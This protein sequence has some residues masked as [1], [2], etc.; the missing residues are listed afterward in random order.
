MN[1][2]HTVSF[3]IDPVLQMQLAK[4]R[5]A[6]YSI[7]VKSRFFSPYTGLSRVTAKI[8]TFDE[9]I[10]T[11]MVLAKFKEQRPVLNPALFWHLLALGVQPA[12]STQSCIK[13]TSGVVA[14]G[15]VWQNSGAYVAKLIIVK[16]KPQLCA[17]HYNVRWN[18]KTAF[19]VI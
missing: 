5:I 4:A 16:D 9:A 11:E 8:V 17:V 7:G 13:N 18:A 19:L 15:S 12:H 10:N 14:L 6:G 2:L 3:V 1:V